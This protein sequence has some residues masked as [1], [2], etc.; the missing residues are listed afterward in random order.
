[1][2]S[3]QLGN[4]AWAM[5]L[6]AMGLVLGLSSFFEKELSTQ[7][8]AA[9]CHEEVVHVRG[10]VKTAVKMGDWSLL[11]LADQNGFSIMI[12]SRLGPSGWLAKNALLDVAGSPSCRPDG[13]WVLARMVRRWT[14]DS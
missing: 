1:M 3:R 6:L 8:S 11:T 13:N 9:L 4:A 12:P 7:W 10:F 2:N 14:W 5:A